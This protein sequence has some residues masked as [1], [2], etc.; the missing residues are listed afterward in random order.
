MK[1]AAVRLG[2]RLKSAKVLATDRRQIMRQP[3]VPTR[4]MKKYANF[5]Q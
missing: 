5:V 4:A 2:T 1:S 3:N